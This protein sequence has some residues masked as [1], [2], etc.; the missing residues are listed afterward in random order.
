MNTVLYCRH[1]RAML[2]F[3]EQVLGLRRGY[4]NEWFVEFQ[5]APAAYLSIADDTRASIKSAA[6]AGITITLRVEDVARAHAQLCAR[7]VTPSPVGPRPWGARGFL[8]H[9]PEGNRIEFWAPRSG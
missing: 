5:V 3:Y 9:D 6:G 1:W 8:L 2:A 7:G 4:A